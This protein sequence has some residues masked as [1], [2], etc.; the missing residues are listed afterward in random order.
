MICF[1]LQNGHIFLLDGNKS[2][3]S[4]LEF[5]IILGKPR[6]SPLFLRAGGGRMLLPAQMTQRGGICS[7]SQRITYTPAAGGRQSPDTGPCKPPPHGRAGNPG[8]RRGE[9]R[10][11][12]PR[13]GPGTSR[14]KSGERLVPEPPSTRR[15]EG[16]VPTPHSLHKRD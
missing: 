7:D 8:K 5:R 14:V 1:F 11:P 4:R 6:G 3:S 16:E 13:A 9:G 12:R 10:L 2:L 15:K